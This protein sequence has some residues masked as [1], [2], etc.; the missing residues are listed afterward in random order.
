MSSR[1]NL[2]ISYDLK[3]KIKEKHPIKWDSKNKTWY[4]EGELPEELDMY[5]ETY[6]ANVDIKYFEKKRYLDISDLKDISP[7]LS[8][9]KEKKQWRCSKKD[10]LQLEKLR[11]KVF[12]GFDNYKYSREID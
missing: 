9:D 11:L 5:I 12:W 6:V 2:C 8:F 10:A 3:D 1:I 4:Y 7:S